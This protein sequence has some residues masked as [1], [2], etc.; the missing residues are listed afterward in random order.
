MSFTLIEWF[1]KKKSDEQGTSL[2][3][4]CWL[5]KKGKMLRDNIIYWKILDSK[6]V[7]FREN[8]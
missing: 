1:Q 3:S 2:P 7:D 5:L 4:S 8:Q 6:L